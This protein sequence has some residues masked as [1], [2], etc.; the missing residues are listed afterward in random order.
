MLH[1]HLKCFQLPFSSALPHDACMI[2]D[3]FSEFR[4]PCF[5]IPRRMDRRIDN[6]VEPPVYWI[7]TYLFDDLPLSF[8]DDHPHLTCP[9]FDSRGEGSP[10]V[11]HCE[12]VHCLP[13]DN[14]FG[15]KFMGKILKGS[16][17]IE[18]RVMEKIRYNPPVTF[19]IPC[20]MTPREEDHAGLA[21]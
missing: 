1:E 2:I 18:G 7:D 20:G 6:A 9:A 17:H 5:C 4:V 11:G 14:L 3:H 16:F 10:C 12:A 21:P 13:A 8:K 19:N 15:K